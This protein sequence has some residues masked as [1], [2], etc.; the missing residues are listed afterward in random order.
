MNGNKKSKVFLLN[1]LPENLKQKSHEGNYFNNESELFKSY[2]FIINFNTWFP[3]LGE[4]DIDE[5]VRIDM[6]RFSMT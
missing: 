5:W 2:S 3:N 6:K 1:S 4:W